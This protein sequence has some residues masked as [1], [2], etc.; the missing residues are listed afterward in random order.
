MV[1]LVSLLF[2]ALSHEYCVKLDVQG[3]QATAQMHGKFIHV[4]AGIGL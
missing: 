4:V 2:S 3:Q 1:V